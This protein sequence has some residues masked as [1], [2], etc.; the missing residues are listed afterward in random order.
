MQVEKL[1]R[2]IYA[3]IFYLQELL[4]RIQVYVSVA[5]R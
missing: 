3:D 2:P 5:F 1:S 4:L